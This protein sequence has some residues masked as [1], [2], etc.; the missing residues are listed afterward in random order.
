MIKNIDDIYSREF[1]SMFR[2]ETD[3]ACAVLG[4]ALLDSLREQ[5]LRHCMISDICDRLFRPSEILS[6]YSAKIQLSN[7]LALLSDGEARE[8]NLIRKIRNQFAHNIESPLSFDKPPVRD[9][10]NELAYPSILV[11]V[12]SKTKNQIPEEELAA[13]RTSPRRRFEVSVG[14]M[15]SLIK[16]KAD[17][18]NPPSG[19]KGWMD[20]ATKLKT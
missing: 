1:V 19:I 13:L 11:E 14:L 17:T 2:S 8:L 3:R 12:H 10:T 20:V 15:A 6:D 18:L 9:Q 4:A 7:S 5:L 16:M